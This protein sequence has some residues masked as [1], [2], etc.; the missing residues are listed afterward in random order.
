MS[1][2]ISDV[3]ASGYITEDERV[4]IDFEEALEANE[5]CMG[6]QAAIAVTC[7]QF[8]VGY[9]DYA[10]ILIELPDGDWLE[11]KALPPRAT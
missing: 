6:E 5:E 4:A 2:N 9:D 8:G 10:L 3:L 11:A 7:E 1:R